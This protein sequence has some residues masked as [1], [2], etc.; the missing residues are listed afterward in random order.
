MRKGNVPLMADEQ[1]KNE[2]VPR[3]LDVEGSDSDDDDVPLSHYAARS[4][5]NENFEVNKISKN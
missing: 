5:A 2:S 4:S 3:E 1:N